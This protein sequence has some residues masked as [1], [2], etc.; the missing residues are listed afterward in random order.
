[1]TELPTPAT[2]KIN[3]FN[4]AVYAI[5]YQQDTRE[6]LRIDWIEKVPGDQPVT[7]CPHRLLCNRRR[8][9]PAARYIQFVRG[10]QTPD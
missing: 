4:D 3:R 5:Y 2:G 8:G 7:A 6:D 9:C 1:L 10:F